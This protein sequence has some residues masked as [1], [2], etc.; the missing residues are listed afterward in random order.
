MTALH[1]DWDHS[2]SYD[3]MSQK[4]NDQAGSVRCVKESYV[5]EVTT[6]WGLKLIL[7]FQS[8]F[9]TEIVPI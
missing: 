4:E 1:A 2:P 8:S 7:E 5:P 6:I 3:F 9:N